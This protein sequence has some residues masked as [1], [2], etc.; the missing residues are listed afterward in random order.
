[1]IYFIAF[2]KKKTNNGVCVWGEEV[3]VAVS[4]IAEGNRE[5]I[6]DLLVSH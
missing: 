5:K 2:I 4:F 3:I 6:T 1:M